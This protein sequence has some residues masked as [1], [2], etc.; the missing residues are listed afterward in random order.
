MEGCFAFSFFHTDRR[1]VT[2]PEY[3]Q[4]KEDVLLTKS[5]M[6]AYHIYWWRKKE[7]MY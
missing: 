6:D 7:S 2:V 4:G 3:S 1:V 5:L